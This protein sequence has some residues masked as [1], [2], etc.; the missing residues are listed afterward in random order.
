MPPFPVELSTDIRSLLDNLRA[1][2][3]VCVAG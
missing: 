3:L 2:L 1:R